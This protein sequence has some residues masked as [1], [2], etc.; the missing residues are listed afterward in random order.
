VN[1]LRVCFAKHGKVRFTSHRDVA[2]MWERAIRR[3]GLPVAYSQGFSPRPRLHFGLALPT[4]HE[5]RAEYLDVDLDLADP[6]VAA[7]PGV[8]YGTVS[9]PGSLDARPELAPERL[10]P[11]LSAALP[12]GV[13]CVGAAFIGPEVPSLQEAVTS[14]T[15]RIEA[16]WSPSP[17]PAT[18]VVPV[19]VGVDA[20]PAPVGVDADPAPVGAIRARAAVAAALAS[21]Q[22]P[23]ERERKGKRTVDDLRP[24]IA[25]LALV[26]AD[27]ERIVL[28]AELATQPRAVRPAELLAVLD[29]RLVEHRVE[30]LHQWT[31]PAG[32]RRE[33]PLPPGA[34]QAPHAEVRAS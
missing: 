3:T 26:E 10:V 4:G 34:T 15:W 31:T 21:E 14:C 28:L 20:D 12:D 11:V 5:S 9:L 32:A 17:R 30:R 33:E 2:R 29:G 7:V 1:R 16:R 19:P 23:L 13:D 8:G 27:G 18:T 6:A 22:L 24:A 25:D